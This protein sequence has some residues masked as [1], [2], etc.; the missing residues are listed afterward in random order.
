MRSYVTTGLWAYHGYRPSLVT[1][2][3]WPNASQYLLTERLLALGSLLSWEQRDVLVT[4]AVLRLLAAT[5]RADHAQNSR[6][7]QQ[8]DEQHRC[9][10][11][12]DAEGRGGRRCGRH[13]CRGRLVSL[14][15]GRSTIAMHTAERDGLLEALNIAQS[16]IARTR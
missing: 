11:L 2:R 9:G 4:S 14:N 7:C 13:K 12:R 16:C 10:V 3:N 15:Q 1:D 6:E 5:A 8:P